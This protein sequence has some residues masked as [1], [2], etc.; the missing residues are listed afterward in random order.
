MQDSIFPGD[1]MLFQGRVEGVASDA[2]GCG[3]VE[4]DVRLT[5]GPRTMTTC[6]VRVAL[7]LHAG[8]NPWRRSGADWQP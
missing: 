2:S 6:A 4:L 5:V 1:R 3:W 8:D 7:P